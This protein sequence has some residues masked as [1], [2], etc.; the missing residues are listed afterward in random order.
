VHHGG[1]LLPVSDPHND[2]WQQRSKDLLSV[3]VTFGSQYGISHGVLN[4]IEK[5]GWGQMHFH[6]EST[7][8]IKSAAFRMGANLLGGSG[9]GLLGTESMSYLYGM[10]PANSDMV[11]NAVASFAVTG[12]S[13]DA[14]HIAEQK[15]VGH[16]PKK[17]T[18]HTAEEHEHQATPGGAFGAGECL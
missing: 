10:G 5:S 8:T 11:K 9:A 7:L 18:A 13:L 15:L 2:F 1:A 6:D 4:G 12:L 17:E 16:K 14:A 3:S